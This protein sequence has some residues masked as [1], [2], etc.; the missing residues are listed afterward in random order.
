MSEQYHIRCREGDVGR[1]VL[2]PGDPG[3]CALIAS[4]FEQAR[5]VMQHREYT[6]YTG[7]LDGVPVSVMSTGIGAPSTAIAVEELCAIGAGTLI[8][9]GTCGAMQNFLHNGDLVIAQAAVRDEG[10]STQYVPLGYPAVAH[11]DAITALQVAAREQGARFFT[12]IVRSGD[13]LYA[14]LVPQSLPLH[15]LTGGSAGRMWSEARVLCADMEA[16]ALF[17]IGAIRG[18]RT[19]TILQVVNATG[20]GAIASN[21]VAQHTLDPLIR[22]AVGS[23]RAL[24]RADAAMGI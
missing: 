14:D 23:L 8:R 22:T 5:L 10:T 4:H 3:R 16:S 9:V 18:L 19:G 17:V 11:L 2:L 24:I 20:E 15:Y 13:A 1:Y 21:A 6:T 12:G 7:T